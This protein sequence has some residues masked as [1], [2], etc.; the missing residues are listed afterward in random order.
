MVIDDF[1]VGFVFQAT[2]AGGQT[3]PGT[4]MSQSPSLSTSVGTTMVRSPALA[5]QG[6]SALKIN[7]KNTCCQPLWPYK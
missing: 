1:P 5:Q 6:W 3:Q 7:L 4:M 2:T